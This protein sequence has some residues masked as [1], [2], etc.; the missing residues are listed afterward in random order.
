MSENCGT[1]QIGAE[2]Q[3]SLLHAVLASLPILRSNRHA[4]VEAGTVQTATGDSGVSSLEEY[5]VPYVREY[6]RVIALCETALQKAG[7]R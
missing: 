5:A 7:L 1:F 6:D 4:V 2:P 3:T